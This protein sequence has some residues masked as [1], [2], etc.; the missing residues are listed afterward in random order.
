MT[1]LNCNVSSCA[2][3]CKGLCSRE[4]VMVNGPKAKR[5]DMTCCESFAPRGKGIPQAHNA[6]VATSVDCSADHCT[7]NSRGHCDA[8]RISV[9]NCGCPSPSCSNE[10][11]C[12]S[13][14]CKD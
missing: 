6:T 14:S 10:T 12:A 1:N 5:P 3:N 2:Y 4:G 9:L 7:F 8:D 11:E 13:F